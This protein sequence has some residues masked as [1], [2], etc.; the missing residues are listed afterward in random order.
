[1]VDNFLMLL[2]AAC[3][4]LVWS[5]ALFAVVF[6]IC[7]IAIMIKTA[8]NTKSDEDKYLS[9]ED[10]EIIHGALAEVAANVICEGKNK[11]PKYKG[12]SYLDTVKML[13]LD[14]QEKID[15]MSKEDNDVEGSEG[16]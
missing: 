10:A 15:A 4:V 11:H 9:K 5:I 6:I 8:I 2:K 14:A 13:A 7:G 12:L 16:D 3:L 1:M